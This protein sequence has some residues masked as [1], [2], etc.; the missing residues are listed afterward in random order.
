M[1]DPDLTGLLRRLDMA[2]QHQEAALAELRAV[3]DEVSASLPAPA[4]VGGT[5]VPPADDLADG[6][7]LDTHAASARFNYPTNTLAKWARTEGL[8]VKRGGRW[9]VSIPRLQR[10]LNG[11]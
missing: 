4:E 8:G 1:P 9:L 7:L 10:R 5:I 11:S 2:L 3:R 6:N